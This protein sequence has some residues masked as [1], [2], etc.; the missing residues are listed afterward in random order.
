MNTYTI[1]LSS[2]STTDNHTLSTHQLIDFTRLTLNLENIYSFTIPSQLIINWGD[3]QQQLFDNDLYKILDRYEINVFNSNPLLISKYS[4]DFSPSDKFLYKELTIQILI[5]Y[6]NG[7]YSSISIPIIIRT[8]DF[9]ESIYELS[10]KE[11]IL[12]PDTNNPQK[13]ILKTSLSNQIFE[14]N[15]VT[16]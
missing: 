3:G 11:S 14:L 15:T 10:L 13:Y 5:L 12:L 4:H 7:D 16:K 2:G 8:N 1:T 9:F 6:T